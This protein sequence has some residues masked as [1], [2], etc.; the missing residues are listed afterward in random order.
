MNRLPVV[1]VTLLVMAALFWFGAKVA[2]G[3]D[4]DTV[5]TRTNHPGQFT[6]VYIT[7]VTGQKL[8]FAHVDQ[9]TVK[10]WDAN[11]LV[12]LGGQ[13]RVPYDNIIVLDPVCA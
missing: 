13:T 9:A 5:C 11:R 6:F 7:T 1:P 8:G 3:A 2:S 12:I 4:D 10:S